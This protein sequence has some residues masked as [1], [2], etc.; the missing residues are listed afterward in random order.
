MC[1]VCA[2]HTPRPAKANR[3][4]KNNQPKPHDDLRPTEG[5]IPHRPAEAVS[6]AVGLPLLE[7]T[8]GREGLEDIENAIKKHPRY[9]HH[10][11]LDSCFQLLFS[12]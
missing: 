9:R 8:H 5:L 3:Q 12:Q 4:N 1:L 6:K 11:A 10:T 7:S 2:Q